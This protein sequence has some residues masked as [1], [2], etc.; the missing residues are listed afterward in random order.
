MRQLLAAAF[1]LLAVQ[2]AAA[3]PAGFRSV[4]IPAEHHG[5]EMSGALWYPSAGGGEANLLRRERRLFR[6]LGPRRRPDGGGTVPCDSREPRPWRQYRRAR[7]AD[8]GPCRG[9]CSR[10]FGQPPE[11]HDVGLRSPGRPQAL[12][13]DAGPPGRARLVCRPARLLRRMRTSPGST[14]WASPPAAGRRLPWGACEPTS[15]A[16]PRTARPCLPHPGNAPT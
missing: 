3:E 14:R 1:L 10:H 12:D 9:G 6:H 7:L 13:S 5:R 16:M 8:R 2:I 11:Q 4:T 15:R